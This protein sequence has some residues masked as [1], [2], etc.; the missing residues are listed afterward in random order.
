[1]LSSR[2]LTGMTCVIETCL[3]LMTT[4]VGFVL[5]PVC[6]SPA[7]FLVFYSSF[8]LETTLLR[9]DNNLNPPAIWR[10][11]C[12]DPPCGAWT[13]RIAAAER[14]DLND[15]THSLL[16]WSSNPN[17]PSLSAKAVKPFALLQAVIRCMRRGRQSS[18]APSLPHHP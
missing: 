14:L 6:Q 5:Y 12:S 17:P 2:V 3:L 13:D 4:F 18:V 16:R 8:S 9:L 1:M 15:S 7:A 11:P 10:L